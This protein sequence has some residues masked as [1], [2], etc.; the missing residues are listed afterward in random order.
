MTEN[1]RVVASTEAL[2]RRDWTSMGTLM[3]AS[4]VSLRDDYEVSCAELDVAVDSLIASG[5]VGARMTGG[6][7]GGSAVALLRADSVE[8]A[9]TAVTAAFSERGWAAPNPFVVSASAG[10]H[11]DF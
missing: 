2:R 6:G 5:A 7:F 1:A 8:R 3:K 9:A 4:H 10:A 11:R